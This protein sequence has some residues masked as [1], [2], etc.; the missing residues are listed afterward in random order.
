M[1]IKKNDPNYNQRPGKLVIL[2][3]IHYLLFSGDIH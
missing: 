1:L 3:N 2:V